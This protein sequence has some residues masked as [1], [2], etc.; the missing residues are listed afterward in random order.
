M[1]LGIKHHLTVI[2]FE[3]RDQMSRNSGPQPLPE[4]WVFCIRCLRVITKFQENDVFTTL[5]DM[6]VWTPRKELQ[7]RRSLI[8]EFPEN[9]SRN[10]QRLDYS[11][12]VPTVLDGTSVPKSDKNT[13]REKKNDDYNRQRVLH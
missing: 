2:D 8:N 9:H 10:D 6:Y 3:L 5:D 4:G 11:P 12:L 13:Y 1:L 7:G